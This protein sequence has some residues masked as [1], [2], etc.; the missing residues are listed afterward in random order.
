[1]TVRPDVAGTYSVLVSATNG[2]GGQTNPSYSYEA[3]VGLSTLVTF[4]TGGAPTTVTLTNVSGTT[5]ASGT[6]GTLVRVNLN[7]ALTGDEA[8]SVTTSSGSIAGATVSG[9]AFTSVAPTAS[10]TARLTK[11]NF[12]SGVAFVNVDVAAAATAVVT[13][14]GTGTLAAISATASVSAA[15]A[16]ADLAALKFAGRGGTAVT[17]GWSLA[18]ATAA[19]TTVN[20]KSTATSSTIEVTHADVDE[21]ETM[22]GYLTVTDKGGNISGRLQ[23]V[24]HLYLISHIQRQVHLP[25]QKLIQLFH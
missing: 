4:T 23:L 9:G 5:N 6:M 25:L 7:G 22:Y 2:N 12:I 18:T 17:T 1:M 3:G 14:T 21:D 19:G 24:T 13:A 11:A 8:I 16:T 15:T 10:T 20:I